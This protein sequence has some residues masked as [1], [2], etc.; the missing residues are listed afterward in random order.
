M[1]A[2][3]EATWMN[4]QH[5]VVG[6]LFLA[7]ASWLLAQPATQLPSLPVVGHAVPGENKIIGTYGQPEWSAR[8]PFPGVSVY[9]QPAGQAE[10]E[11]GY[12]DALTSRDRH[13]REWSAEIEIGLPHRFQIALEDDYTNFREGSRLRTWH[14]AGVRT[15]VRYALADWGKV[16]LNPALGLGRRFNS[17]APDAMLY[18]FALGDELTPRWHWG[19]NAG[20]ERQA[21]A[22]RL[23]ELAASAA[24]TYSVTNETLNVGVQGEWKRAYEVGDAPSHLRRIGFGPCVQYRP[25]DRIHLD[26]V[27]TFGTERGRAVHGFRLSFGFEFGEGSDDHDD[28]ERRPGGRFGH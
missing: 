11:L 22:P 20:Y 18:E 2:A 8:R 28:D 4:F 7:S 3:T 9:V 10:F 26:L 13:D 24:L 19:A 5:S 14:Q 23:R 15:A 6:I 1:V 27:T 25:V 16:P 21:G 17:A 12:V